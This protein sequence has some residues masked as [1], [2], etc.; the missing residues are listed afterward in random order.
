M[1]KLIVLCALLMSQLSFAQSLPVNE[2]NEVLRSIE[3]SFGT[4]NLSCYNSISDRTHR[5]TDLNWS[6]FTD[7]NVEINENQ[8]PVISVYKSL[9]ENRDIIAKITTDE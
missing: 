6:V 5:A 2:G 4:H 8:Q 3:E 1:K 9:G 7:G